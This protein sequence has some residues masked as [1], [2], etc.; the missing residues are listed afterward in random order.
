[1]K[2]ATIDVFGLSALGVDLESCA[3]LKPSPV[4]EAFDYLTDQY[5]LRLQS[6]LNPAS[7]LYFLPTDAN[8]EHAQKIKLLRS[9]IAD[10][11]NKARADMDSGKEFRKT[12]FMSS[13]LKADGEKETMSNDAISDIMMVLL[14]GGYDTTSI[15]L[16]YALYLLSKHPEVEQRA[17]AEIQSVMGTGSSK[18]DLQDPD[19]LPYTKAV[20]METLRLYPPAPVTTRNLEK[21]LVLHGKTIPKKTMAYVPIWSIQRYEGNYPRPD[22]FRPD[23]WVKRVSSNSENAVWDER[24]E[25]EEPDSRVEDYVPPANRDAFCAFSGGGRNCVGR[26]LAIQEAVTI[27][28]CLLRDLKFECNVDYEVKPVLS[29]FIQRPDDNLPMVMKARD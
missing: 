10:L 12:E 17:V 11:I 25:G 27:L 26:A 9:F 19:D 8:R 24:Y 2:M 3:N 1:M 5:T 23:R 13:L 6:P 4:A 16:A 29:S 20:I 18:K 22:E 14:F 21:D 28:A 15:T 7:S